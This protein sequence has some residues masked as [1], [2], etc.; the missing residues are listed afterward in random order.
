[1]GKKTVCGF[2]LCVFIFAACA[3]ICL[4]N[5]DLL[6]RPVFQ[7][8]M[9]FSNAAS[10]K[11]GKDGNLY[12]IDNGAFRFISMTPEGKIN[13]SININKKREYLKFYDSAVDDAGNLYLYATELAYDAY[14]TKRDV[15]RK[16]DRRGK[17]IK[18]IFTLN[19]GE[20]T[21]NP[22][23]SPHI[24]SLRCEN[25]ILTFSAVRR[26]R[27]DL[28]S[29]DTFREELSISAFAQGMPDFSVAQLALKD[30]E[31]F[32]YTTRDG[33]IYE[34]RNGAP[35][36]LRGSFD[37][38]LDEGGIVPWYLDYDSQ[39]N[40]LF[41]DM[42]SANIFRINRGNQTENVLPSVL[43]DELRVRGM[44]L[45]L[46]GFGS[47]KNHFAGVYGD[48]V[49]YYD[50]ENFKTYEEGIEL[51][52]WERIA[53]TATQSALCLGFIVFILGIYLLFVRILNGY[54]SLFIKLAAV[55]IPPV[56]AA[57]IVGYSLTFNI[58]VERL[59]QEIFKEM[60]FISVMAVQSING[61]DIDSLKSIKDVNGDTYKR[62]TRAIKGITGN[63]QEEWNKNYYVA[64]YKGE[65]F[66]YWVALS[67]DE[68]GLFRPAGYFS[69]GDEDYE[70]VMSGK[71]SAGVVNSIDGIWGYSV[72]PVYNSRGEIAGMF[73]LGLDMT[74]HQIRNTRL[75]REISLIA[76]LI[77]LITLLAL[78][79][80]MSVI[81]RRLS[82]MAKVLAA[83]GGGNYKARVTYRA[84]DELG[85]VSRGLNNMAEELQKQFEYI[86]RLNKSSIRFVPVQFMEHL[87]VKDITKMKLGDNVQRDLTVLF[88]DIRSFSISSEMMPARENFLFINEILGVAGPILRKHN[89][90]VDK[91]LGDAAMAL[92]ADAQDAVRAGIEIYRQLILNKKTRIKIGVDGIN[93]GV[94]LHT[95]SVMM[96]IVG[97]NERLSSTVISKT[98]NLAS[99]MESLT[100][101]TNSGMLITRDTLNQLA[102]G[103]KEFTYR[104]IG[105]IQAAG[106]NEVIGVFDM[107]D[108]LP[109]KIRSRRIATKKVF[110]SGIRHYHI[111]DYQ[112]AL[113]R[114][115]W[116]VAADPADACAAKCLVETRKRLE[117]PDLPSVFVFDKK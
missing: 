105:M 99:R 47:F 109:K 24:G 93:I 101:Q 19:Y 9:E 117:D 53:V 65:H 94:G 25:G 51:S 55:I 15:I 82:L 107:L 83:I 75:Q 18:E 103:E 12:I 2:I 48:V 87:G 70:V 5:I 100:K 46:T 89:G 84:K 13:Y 39:G 95:G 26:N 43:F 73:E 44:P 36:V 4:F 113:K 58:M 92:F 30:F 77:S 8:T 60:N 62:V 49:W 1:M 114:F 7:K 85:R 79:A 10:A 67:N 6:T 96:G 108:A 63:N 72:I 106:V 41:S 21:E 98:V 31:N 34:V 20:N 81:V 91:Y 54:V 90:F 37:F 16:Y 115:E 42:I 69:L 74:S 56:I 3:A 33:N 86:T 111:K 17:L 102:G 76:A 11:Y 40:I 97:E 64:L 50:G 59:N 116:V 14:M 45:F 66:E 112:N 22:Q 61:D 110:E 35:P 52:L 28:F 27:V 32:I 71:P 68:M 88:F 80:V 38:I 104:F 23:T 29:Y 57:F 78:T